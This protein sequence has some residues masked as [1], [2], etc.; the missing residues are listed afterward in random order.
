MLSALRTGRLYPLGN[1]PGTHLCE[2]LSRLQG[3]TA[4]G[5]FMSL[6]NSNDTIGNRNRDLPTCGAVPQQTAPPR[7]TVYHKV[8]VNIVRFGDRMRPFY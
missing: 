6:K 7:A 3:H 4:A 1:A 2:I 8:E 5:R